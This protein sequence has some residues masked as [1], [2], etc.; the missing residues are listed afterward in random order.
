MLLQRSGF[1][2]DRTARCVASARFYL[3]ALHIGRDAFV[4]HE[5]RVYGGAGAEVRIGEQVD[6]APGVMFLAGT[7]EIGGRTR[8]AGAGRG[9]RI[10]VGAGTWIGAGSLIIGPATIGRG[11]VIGAGA[12]VRVN[13][14]DHTIYMSEG[15]VRPVV[16]DAPRDTDR[17]MA[18][19]MPDDSAEETV[20]V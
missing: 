18:A 6:I 10:E 8:R 1:D 2:V 20:L 9:T 17:D 3:P 15:D 11:C 7:H 5:V 12:V 16:D 4:G 14:P 19:G 13:V